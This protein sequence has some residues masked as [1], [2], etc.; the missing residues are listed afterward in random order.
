M[1]CRSLLV[2]Q[3]CLLWVKPLSAD[4]RQGSGFPCFLRD[5]SLPT[6]SL[7]LL[8]RPLQVEVPM[9]WRLGYRVLRGKESVG[10]LVKKRPQM[11]SG[12]GDWRK[13]KE[14]GSGV[15]RDIAFIAVQAQ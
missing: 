5:P 1:L 8:A 9:S 3:A 14:K 10:K 2:P 4:S 13:E 11:E 7:F 15:R 6:W 12:E